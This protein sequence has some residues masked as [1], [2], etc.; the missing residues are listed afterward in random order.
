MQ[1]SD[2]PSFENS[3]KFFLTALDFEELIEQ[4]AE[5]IIASGKQYKYIYGIPRG[6]LVP[7]VT[8]SHYLG[9]DYKSEITLKELTNEALSKEVLVVDD[10]VDTGKAL[11]PFNSFDTAVLYRKPWTISEPT[12]YIEE[13][14]KWIVFPWERHRNEAIALKKAMAAK[15]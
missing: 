1:F 15:K 14:D 4:L 13:T 9:V 11:V 8:L 6:G 3:D 10:L 12:F 5:K 2:H 7:A